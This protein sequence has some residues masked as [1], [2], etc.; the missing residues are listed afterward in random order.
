MNG[1]LKEGLRGECER[2]NNWK[3]GRL[4]G[5]QTEENQHSKDL[6]SEKDSVKAVD[7]EGRGK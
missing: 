4:R 2:G 7:A 3:F 6:D 5:K 1:S